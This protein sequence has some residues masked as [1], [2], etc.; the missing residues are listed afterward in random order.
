MQLPDLLK[1][2]RDPN[3]LAV[4]LVEAIEHANGG[5]AQTVDGSE[6]Y[7]GE[8]VLAEV[9]SDS[10]LHPEVEVHGEDR[11][12]GVVDSLVGHNEGSREEDNQGTAESTLEDP[13]IGTMGLALVLYQKERER[14]A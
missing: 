6:V 8:L 13:V 5:Q 4:E 1:G 3:V 7:S 14:S 10:L 11:P 9:V 2:F 12:D